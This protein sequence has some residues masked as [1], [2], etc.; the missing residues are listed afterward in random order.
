MG[1]QTR[2]TIHAANLDS[3]IGGAVPAFDRIELVNSALSDYRPDSTAM[4]LCAASD[5][6]PGQWLPIAGDLRDALIASQE[7]SAASGGAFS[8]A[9]GPAVKLWRAARQGGFLPTEAQ[10]QE[11]IRLSDWSNIELDPT[12]GQVRFRARGIRLDF[13][14]IGKG[15]AAQ[16]A[17][18]DLCQRGFPRSMVALAGDI[19]VGDPPPGQ[20]GWRISVREGLADL[21]LINAAVSTSGDAEQFVEIDGTK[22]SH[23]VDV[24]TGLGFLAPRGIQVTVVAR[25]GAIADALGTAL[26]ALPLDRAPPL[27]EQFHAAA[28]IAIGEPDS[29]PE[30]RIIDPHRILCWAE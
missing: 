4:Q 6:Q 14:G 3:A 8:V 18:D 12:L 29:Q 10:R 7:V 27:L 25:S 15:Y 21:I 16:V 19:A 30:I 1:V 5:V 2:V 11:A 23:I 17:I 28:I 9:V 22:Y 26:Y 13:G 20:P 24:R